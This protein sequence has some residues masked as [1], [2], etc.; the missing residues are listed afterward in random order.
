MPGSEQEQVADFGV[1]EMCDWE[2]GGVADEMFVASIEIMVVWT[3]VREVV[4]TGVVVGKFV[5]GERH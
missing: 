4:G 2:V 1:Y 5:V 3:V